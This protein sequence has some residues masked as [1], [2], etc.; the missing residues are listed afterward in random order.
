M[1]RPNNNFFMV[2]KMLEQR[3]LFGTVGVPIRQ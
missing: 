1:A 3:I 2:K